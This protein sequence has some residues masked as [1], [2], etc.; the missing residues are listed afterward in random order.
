L[1]SF[2]FVTDSEEVA[3][4]NELALTK[5]IRDVNDQILWILYDLVSC[6][7]R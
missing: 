7:Y 5:A 3:I 4:N 2:A 1:P 6:D